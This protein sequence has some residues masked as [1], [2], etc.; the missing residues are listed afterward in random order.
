MRNRQILFVHRP[1]GK[2]AESDFAMQEVDVPDLASGEVLCRTILLSVDP[3]NRAWM[4]GRTYRD[5]LGENELMSGFTISEV[6]DAG[7]T[8]LAAGTIVAGDGGWQEY[9]TPRATT[10][11]PVDVRG[12][13][14]HHMSALGVTG[15]TAYFGMLEVGRPAPGETVVVSAAAGA[16]GSVAGQVARIAGARVVGITGSDAKNSVLVDECGFDAA[17]NYRSDTFRKDLRAACPNGADVYFDNVGGTT[18]ETMLRVMN[19]HGRIA[20]CGAVSQYDTS[21]PG[22]GPSGVPGLLVTKRLRA[23]GFL[24][25]DFMADWAAAED[26]LAGWIASGELTVLEDVMEGLEMAPAALVGILAGDNIGKRIVR[27]APDPS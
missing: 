3:A 9:A 4:A 24:V 10:L 12:P 14:S 16:T 25:S 5:Q 23:E 20:C 1:E 21:D 6:V 17:V 18:L 26:R 8:Q 19:V 15:L 7:D 13:L 22:P 27:V 11:R 2:L